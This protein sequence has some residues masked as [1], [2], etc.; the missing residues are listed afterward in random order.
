[1]GEDKILL[2]T[3]NNSMHS[4]VEPT[5]IFQIANISAIQNILSVMILSEIPL[6]PTL[7]QLKMVKSTV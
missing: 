1:M 4:Y 5:L 2:Y 7:I 6:K 3:I